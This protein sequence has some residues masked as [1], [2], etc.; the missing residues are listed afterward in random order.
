MT[1]RLKQI[2]SGFE[3]A[4]TRRLTGR[5]VDNIVMPSRRAGESAPID[6]EAPSEAAFAALKDRLSAAGRKAERAA[7]R[8]G[9]RSAY[10]GAVQGA[11]GDEAAAAVS[12]LLKGLA[13]TE[14]RTARRATADY[15]SHVSSDPKAAAKL[16]APRKKFLGLF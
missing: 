7:S 2:W 16:F 6:V 4:T 8:R 11:R 9:E 12:D 15:V 14:A 1:D 13:A 10:D 5:G 3:G